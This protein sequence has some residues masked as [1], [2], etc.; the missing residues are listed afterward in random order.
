M[1]STSYHKKRC[2][3]F[4]LFIR[5]FLSANKFKPLKLQIDYTLTHKTQSTLTHVNSHTPSLSFRLPYLA[6]TPHK[7][8]IPLP[9][10]C[11]AGSLHPISQPTDNA[12]NRSANI[13]LPVAVLVL[14][15][16]NRIKPPL[17]HNSP[18]LLLCR[19]LLGD[20]PISSSPERHV[21]RRNTR[22]A[23]ITLR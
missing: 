12:L 3:T 11:L 15:D 22:N 16:A 10:F 6:Y 20:A 23:Y 18:H 7:F 1:N 17:L 4:K 21:P 2:V 13:I 8:I 14:P 19:H 9:P 5:L